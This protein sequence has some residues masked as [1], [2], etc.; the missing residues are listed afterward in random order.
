M[1]PL[2]EARRR[3]LAQCQPLRPRAV[4]LDAA[5]GCVVSVD[6]TA[7][8]AVP[9]FANSAVDG[10]AVRAGDTAGS[11]VKLDVVGTI[12]AGAPP[13]P[14]VGPGQ[15]VRIL[16][17]APVPPGADAVVMVED[18]DA[19]D[20]RSG[21]EAVGRTDQTAVE[22]RRPVAAGDNVRAAGSDIA[23]G[24]VIAAAGTELTA[25]RLGVLASVGLRR[26][27]VHPRARVGVLSTGD[28]LI[29]GGAELRPGQIRDSNRH[30]L[31]ATL[32]A[33]G[34]EAI[35]LEIVGDDESALTGRIEDGVG[36]CDAILT[37]GGVSVG[38]F[39]YVKVVLDRLSGGGV[40]WMQVAIRP[41]KP[42]AFGLIDGVPV[43]GLPG[44]PVSSLVSFEC[45]ARPALRRMTGH[46][47]VLRPT[48]RAVADEALHRRP[49]GKLHL[50]RARAGFGPDGRV[51]VRVAG[52]QGS[53][54]LQAMAD[55]NA[56]VLVPDGDGVPAGGEADAWLLKL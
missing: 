46:G 25:A 16:T 52:G 54:Q 33:S 56:L 15:S 4:D 24:S 13:E 3:I 44:N 40:T 14:P 28:E 29:E 5:L 53:H 31:L 37:S 41:A 9:P 26:V 43:F 17:G 35:D 18:T 1:I 32:A 47:E 39:D 42:F 48:V 27:P 12:P 34:F 10:F 30:A 11:P 22:V 38:D 19:W 2:E 20:G 55:A 21:R 7:E 50:V 6:V 8:E 45:F 49:D 36:R 23:P 51:H